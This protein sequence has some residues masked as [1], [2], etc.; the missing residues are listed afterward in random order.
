MRSFIEVSTCDKCG[1]EGQRAFFSGF[2]VILGGCVDASGNN[3]TE[4]IDFDLCFPCQTNLLTKLLK[5]KEWLPNG[6]RPS[7]LEG[8]IRSLVKNA[9]TNRG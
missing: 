6:S 7:D 8:Y 3:A 5:E 4:T 2:E 9:Q 1:K